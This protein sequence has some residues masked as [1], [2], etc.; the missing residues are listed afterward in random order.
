MG[1]CIGTRISLLHA[2]ELY[3]VIIDQI[4]L[5]LPYKLLAFT[6]AGGGGSRQ[7]AFQKRQ[8]PFLVRLSFLSSGPHRVFPAQ[9]VRLMGS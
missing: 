4:L 6:S 3:A 7:P 9:C 8:L 5:Q 1:A 2:N